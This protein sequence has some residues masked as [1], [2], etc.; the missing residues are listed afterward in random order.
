[1]RALWSDRPNCSHNV[2]QKVKR[3]SR[4]PKGP[5][6]T[7]NTTTVVKIVNYYAVVFLLRPPNLL[8]RGPFFER[9]K[10]LQFPG[11][12]CPHKALRNSKSA[13]RTKNTTCSQFT[14]RSIFS[15]AGS[16]GFLKQGKEDQ[17]I[18]RRKKESCFGE[19]IRLQTG[20]GEGS[21]KRQMMSM[22]TYVNITRLKKGTQGVRARYAAVLPPF[23]STLRS[24]GRPVISPCTSFPC[25]FWISLF[26]FSTNFL[27]FWA[28]FLFFPR[29]FG[30]R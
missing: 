7:K 5:F 21:T 17:G 20:L 19:V 11:K 1:M 30:V 14:T 29:I 8:R 28:C 4:L 18:L 25:C 22:Q 6:R 13:R 9:E 3:I 23:I 24:P 12:W 27:V 16:F 15:T 26:F 2:S 10:C